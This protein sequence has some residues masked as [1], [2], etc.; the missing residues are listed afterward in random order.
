MHIP[1]SLH[2]NHLNVL[3]AVDELTQELGRSPRIAEVAARA[4]LSHE[5]VLEAMEVD[6]PL[7]L[8][9]AAGGGY[10]DPPSEEGGL[11]RVEDRAFVARLVGPLP[12]REQRVLALRFVDGLSQSQIAERLGVS[13]MAISRLL[14]RS[15]ER[16]RKSLTSA[17]RVEEGRLPPP[18]HRV[19]RAAAS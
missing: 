16:M 5:K 10:L 11:E 14:A 18:A 7:P 3:A 2:D 15:L 19:S 6:R 1:R 9:T 12:E 13:Q 8:D 4:G 17:A